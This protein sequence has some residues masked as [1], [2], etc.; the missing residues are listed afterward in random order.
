MVVPS[1]N[2]MGIV[3]KYTILNIRLTLIHWLLHS[4]LLEES[5]YNDPQ[6][7]TLYQP[8]MGYETQ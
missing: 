8:A 5:H 7:L 6:T 1:T 2:Q 4:G 3:G